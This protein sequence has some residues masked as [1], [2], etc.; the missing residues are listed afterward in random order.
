MRAYTVHVPPGDPPAP[1]R[2]AFVKDGFSWPALFVPVLWILWHRL[3]LTLV[4][5]IIFVL[6]L[7]WTERLANEN[8]A[9][10]LGILGGILFA[11]EANT[12]RRLS[13]DRRGWREMG[14]SFGRNLEDAEMRFFESWAKSDSGVASAGRR[15]AIARAA[16]AGPEQQDRSDE[17]IFGLFPEPER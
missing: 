1:E 15:K 11:L 12:I 16:Y 7:M 6:V 2:F 4:G 14:G 17:P 13:L 5:Y 3:W 9:T 8:A 10:L